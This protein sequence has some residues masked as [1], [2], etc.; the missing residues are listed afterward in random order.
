MRTVRTGPTPHGTYN[1]YTNYRCRCRPCKDANNEF[2]RLRRERRKLTP[3]PMLEAHAAETIERRVA[4]WKLMYERGVA[5]RV[6]DAI[7][8]NRP[9]PV[10]LAAALFAM[11]E[12]AAA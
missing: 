6:A 8:R 10:A 5:G 1:G 12:E 3:D 9:V 7:V 4:A 2:E 11:T